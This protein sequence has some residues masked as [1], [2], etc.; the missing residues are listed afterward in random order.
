M[1]EYKKKIRQF[2]QNIYFQIFITIIS[3]FSLYSDDIRTASTDASAD[4]GFD[5]LHIIFMAI[6]TTEI[7]LNFISIDEYRFSFFFVLDV[8]S[9]LSI[10]LDVSMV[11]AL[12]Y[13]NKYNS[14][15][16]LVQAHIIL[17]N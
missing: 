13:Q 8:V 4:I 10:L 6:F 9:C 14:F 12:M 3:L 2:L 17:E 1:S 15:L 5:T 7:I 16:F 11:T